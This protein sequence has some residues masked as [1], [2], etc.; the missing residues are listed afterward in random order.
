M[1]V[2]KFNHQEALDIFRELLTSDSPVWIGRNGGSDT[3]FV[4]RWAGQSFIED[5]H[6]DLLRRLNGYFDPASSVENLHKFKDMY[7]KSSRN[8]DLCTVH[9]SSLFGESLNLKPEDLNTLE[10]KYGLKQIMCWRFI[11]NCTYFLKS[12]QEWGAQRRILVVSPFSES[13]LFQT[14]PTRVSNLHLPEFKFPE[15]SFTTV[16]TPITYNT[17]DWACAS[18]LSSNSNWFDIADKIFEQI[19]AAEFDIAWLSCGSYAMYLGDRIKN[20][21]GKKSIYVGGMLNVF[22]NLYNF[23]YSSTGHDRAVID[24]AYQIEC[25]ENRDFYTDQNTQKFAFSEGIRAYFGVR[26]SKK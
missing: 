20:E 24:P 19:K 15:C 1:R 5:P 6:V 26:N 3:D 23:R 7:L 21:L 14:H 2:L 4:E 13:V 11:E 16:S 22:F 9:M 18:E 10:S 25:L 17:N 8:M 12:F